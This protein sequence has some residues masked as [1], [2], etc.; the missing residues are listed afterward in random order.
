M[1]G[2]YL[3]GN[4]LSG[5]CVPGANATTYAETYQYHPAGGVTSKTLTVTRT[6][7][8]TRSDPVALI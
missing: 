2:P 7:A 3:D 6:S 4:G 8:L 1:S 5:A